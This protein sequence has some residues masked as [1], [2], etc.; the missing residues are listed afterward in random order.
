MKKFLWIFAGGLLFSNLF[1]STGCGDD[2]VTVDDTPPLVSFAS[3]SG[4]DQTV[5]GTD[6]WVEVTVDAAKGTNDLKAITVYD[7]GVKVGLDRLQFDGAAAAANPALITGSDVT[8]FSRVVKINVQDTYSE[9]TYTI[10]V[11]DTKALKDE[12]T[13]KVTTLEPI[14]N[15]ETGVL[16]NQA[17]AAG[18]GGIDLDDGT[19]TGTKQSN[20]GDPDI[21]ESYLRAELRDMGIDSL[22]GSGDNW[23]L[24]WGGMN[25][26]EVRFLGN[27]PTD[28]NFAAIDSKQ[29]I[30]DRFDEATAID[31][32]LTGWGS[33]KVSGTI[34]IGDVFVIKKGDDRTYL[35][36]VDDITETT[37][38]GD[39]DDNYEVSIKY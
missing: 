37:V 29:A 4:D 19:T 30:T 13:F 10:E 20:T 1:L 28:F 39:N 38:L 16:W 3:G 21:D 9:N 27:N 11:E 7:D 26:V 22:A 15:T 32:T 18:F 6:V 5:V 33:F 17:G 12:V 14:E 36:Q 25:G 23:R 2:P 8:G 31:G 35:V 34:A 24:L